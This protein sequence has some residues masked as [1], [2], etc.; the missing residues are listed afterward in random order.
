MELGSS[1]ERW[2][3]GPA[4]D[5]LAGSFGL[6]CPRG[7]SDSVVVRQPRRSAKLPGDHGQAMSG[8]VMNL[9][10][11]TSQ[12]ACCAAGRVRSNRQSTAAII[13]KTAIVSVFW[14]NHHNVV[15]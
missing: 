4:P 3:V 11:T 10:S 9:R 6:G 8:G 5:S 7:I 13:V 12:I 15:V 2:S 14:T 1:V